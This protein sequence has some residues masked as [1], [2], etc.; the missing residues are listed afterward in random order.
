MRTTPDCSRVEA[1]LWRYI[2]RELSASAL[3][4]ISAHLK[5]CGRCHQLYES[6]SR[7]VKLYRLAFVGSPFGEDFVA[8]FRKRLEA[9]CAHGEARS[10][11]AGI[12]SPEGPS[13][14]GAAGLSGSVARFSLAAALV[15]IGALVVYGLMFRPGLGRLEHVRAVLVTRDGRPVA[16]TET[17]LLPGDRFQLQGKTSELK[18]QLLDGSELVFRGP[19]D[20]RVSL[21]SAPRGPFL[22]SMTEGSL[23][24]SVVRRQ[25]GRELTVSTENATARVVGTRFTLEADSAGTTLAVE[26]GEVIFSGHRK[27]DQVYVN[28]ATGAY[29]VAAGQGWPKPV[30]SAA[31]AGAGAAPPDAVAPVSPSRRLPQAGDPKS[32]PSASGAEPPVNVDLPVNGEK[33]EPARS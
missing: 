5:A 25:Q 7:D 9:E 10:C 8:R 11:A 29:I 19:G 16:S 3:A 23:R 2:D 20:V 15:A 31:P 1:D 18:L 26:E 33:R 13:R 28:H 27:F 12:P 22:A 24:A 6:R 30:A 17:E 14:R 32:A 4:H 21:D